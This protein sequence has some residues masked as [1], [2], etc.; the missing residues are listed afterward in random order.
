MP[1][2]LAFGRQMGEGCVET[3]WHGTMAA[4]EAAQLIGILPYLL[5]TRWPPSWYVCVVSA[6]VAANG[7]LC[8]GTALLG[9]ERACTYRNIDVGTNVA[10]VVLVNCTTRWQPHTL[11]LTCAA[12]LFWVCTHCMR[13]GAARGC[14]HVFGVQCTLFTC[15]REWTF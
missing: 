2:A 3:R 13:V 8:H 10:L 15:L 5:L 11:C 14:L 7:V 1:S 12:V 4:M 6:V 9:H